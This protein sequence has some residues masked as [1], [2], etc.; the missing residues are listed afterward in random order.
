VV[1]T[2]TGGEVS[3]TFSQ[4]QSDTT[5]MRLCPIT[6]STHAELVGEP[7]AAP[8]A[9]PYALRTSIATLEGGRSLA[10]WTEPASGRVVGQLREASGD[11][12]VI[13][14]LSSETD[15]LG[16]PTLTRVDGGRVVVAY[17]TAVERGFDLVA[18]T[19][20]VPG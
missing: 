3:A 1:L 12:G 11:R 2:A 18:V 19:L 16:S 20:E 14:A 7:P 13:F 8:A 15:V 17:F 4:H 10:V 5:T 9:T 6:L